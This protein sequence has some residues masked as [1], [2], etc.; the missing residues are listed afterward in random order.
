MHGDLHERVE[1]LLHRVRRVPLVPLVEVRVYEHPVG[2]QRHRVADGG[3]VQVG[4]LDARAHDGPV[5]EALGAQVQQRRDEQRELPGVRLQVLE[6]EADDDGVEVV[7]P[8]EERRELEEDLLAQPHGVH[9]GVGLRLG[10]V[11]LVELRDL[12]GEELR[13]DDLRA[14]GCGGFAAEA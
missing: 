4:G 10:R 8:R 9:G 14:R 13:V 12:L 7:E 6:V 11:L 3:G 5:E 1:G 2:P